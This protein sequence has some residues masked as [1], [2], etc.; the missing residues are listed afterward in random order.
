VRRFARE[1]GVDVA[2]V[3]GSGPGGRVSIGDVKA[4][5]RGTR[6]L[7]AE[8]VGA[9]LSP[10]AEAPDEERLEWR[11]MSG[12]RRAIAR[13]MRTSWTTIP[14]VTL[15]AVADTTLLQRALDRQREREDDEATRVGLTA[16]L[17]RVL[18]L[19]LRAH[20]E[21]NA[22]IDEAGERIGRRDFVHLGVAVDTERGL[23][24]PVL[25]DADEAGAAELA[26]ELRR[27]AE[28]ARAGR[29]KPDEMSGGS[30]TLTNLGT[31][32][33]ERFT[34]LL[35]P[36]QAV[37]LGMGR[38]RTS[39]A[40]VDGHPEPRL[41]LPLSLSFDHRVLDG[42]DAARL[43]QWIVRALEDP[44]SLLLQDHPGG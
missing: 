22:R 19:A 12:V 36:G 35:V 17:V 18:A 26:D 20:P 29:L 1:I 34:P 21:A 14:H 31:L 25:R 30:A 39:V 37:V 40:W 10:E 43:V 23:L 13:R 28:R 38:A 3:A 11:P 44:W 15:H 9:G 6:E 27:L 32:G 42:A 33:I 41:E 24:V 4:H 16:V 2:R 8:Q 7:R 5:A